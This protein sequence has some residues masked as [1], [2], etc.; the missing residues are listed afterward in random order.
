[1]IVADSVTALPAT[2]RGAVLLSGSHGGAYA[3][4]L[5][6]SAGVRA[7]ILNDAG[8][9]R[10]RAGVSG[11][12]LLDTIG[13]AAATISHRSAR[14]GDGEDGRRRGVISH[15]NRH[16]SALGVKA[17]MAAADAFALLHERALPPSGELEVQEEHRF[18]EAGDPGGPRIVVVDSASLV[19]FADTGQLIVTGSHGGLL[20]GDPERA[21]K[22]AALAAVFNDAGV[23]I[24]KAG[25]R[26]LAALDAR[27]MAA[28]T[29]SADSACIGDGRS[30]LEDGIVSHIN[31]TARQCGGRVGMVARDFLRTIAAFTT[32]AGKRP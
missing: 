4:Y 20:G 1:M 9:G 15:A 14:I 30:T 2:A 19:D 12:V 10:D 13:M 16:A 24:E 21:L 17:G 28:A 31:D 3:A 25:I 8:V 22:T 27:G 32:G 7:V 18:E 6:A 11:L 23:G 29:V 26:R 5:A